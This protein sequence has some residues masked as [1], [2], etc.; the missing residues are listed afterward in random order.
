MSAA[1]RHF[2]HDGFERTSLDRIAADAKVSKQAIYA[3][4]RDKEDLFDQ[5]VRANLTGKLAAAVPGRADAHAALEAVAMSLSGSLFAPR[6]FGL[7]RANIL[8]MQ[9]M[10]G[11]SAAIRDYRRTASS[12]IA[13]LLEA[14]AVQ[15]RIDGPAGQSMD[16]ATRLG[17]LA[18][19]GTRHFLG[20]PPPSPPQ[21]R[22]QVRLAVDLFLH[23]LAAVAAGDCSPARVRSAPRPGAPVDRSRLRLSRERF[24]ALCDAA[25]DE[26]LAHGFDAASLGR[27][28]TDSGI[29]R[30]TIY[31][32]FGSKAGLFEHV[33]GREVVAAARVDI[34]V[35][36]A[37]GPSRQLQ[38]LCRAAL[39]LHLEP[40]SIRLHQL[41]VQESARFPVLARSFYDGQVARIGR[42]FARI[43]AAAGFPAP[44]AAVVRACHTLATFGVRYLVTSREVPAGERDAVSAQAASIMLRGVKR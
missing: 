6:N 39:D 30:A 14:L 2:L 17:G 31:R 21:R 4:F 1:A 37:G 12:E 5:V 26:F 23:G 15:G 3:S 10:P 36:R 18:V 43:A 13:C 7:F 16:L 27:I 25:A 42:P 41:L 20:H 44:Q 9:R 24:A 22:A 19:E 8:A 38:R 32:Q 28:T 33:I 40:R 29:A 34:A 11:L 35:P